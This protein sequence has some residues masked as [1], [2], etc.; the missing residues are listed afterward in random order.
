MLNETGWLKSLSIRRKQAFATLCLVEFCAASGIESA[1]VGELVEH[2]LSILVSD[3]LTEWEARGAKLELAG[4]GDPLPDS[5]RMGLPPGIHEEVFQR[6]GLAA[7]LAL[8]LL[9]A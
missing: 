9:N 2:L 3:N 7:D 4:R 5:V 1:A 8:H 6:L